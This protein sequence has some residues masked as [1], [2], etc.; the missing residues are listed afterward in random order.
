MLQA[1]WATRWRSTTGGCLSSAAA[2]PVMLHAMPGA[3]LCQGPWPCRRQRGGS[4]P[5]PEPRKLLR[6]AGEQPLASSRLARSVVPQRSPP[7]IQSTSF[8][9]LL[10]SQLAI[11]L[12]CF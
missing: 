5:T 7:H 10:I 2:R 9:Q 1:E 3:S 6:S 4:Q 11:P 12:T 8:C